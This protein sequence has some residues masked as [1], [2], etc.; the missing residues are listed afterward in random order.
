MKYHKNQRE[1]YK[2]PFE[3]LF[4]DSATDMDFVMKTSK[5]FQRTFQEH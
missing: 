3:K 5:N 2:T 1:D 4:P